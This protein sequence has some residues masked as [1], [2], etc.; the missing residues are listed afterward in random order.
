MEKPSGSTSRKDVNLR[1]F[2]ARIIH[3]WPFFGALCLLAV[4]PTVI[5]TLLTHPVYEA[6]A[7]LSIPSYAT[8]DTYS[9]NILLND[10]I[11]KAVG[12]KPG[13]ASDILTHIII[14]AD[15]KDKTTYRITVQAD[16]GAQ[17]ALEAN[18]WAEQ[19]IRWISQNLL[20]QD[21]P[22]ANKTRTDLKNADQKLLDFL[23]AQ[24][25][26]QYSLIDL[27]IYEG[28]YSP[29]DFS[30]YT[31]PLEPLDLSSDTHLELG[32]LLRDELNAANNYAD[33]VKSAQQRPT[34]VANQRPNHSQPRQAAGQARPT[35]GAS[36]GKKR[37]AGIG[38]EFA[39]RDLHSLCGRLVE[40]SARL[41]NPF[42][43][44]PYGRFPFP[45]SSSNRFTN[46]KKGNQSL[47]TS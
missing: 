8:N 3:R 29:G 24:N 19:G 36:S 34:A 20:G 25:L 28:L 43:G 21:R 23:E 6:T 47:L 22:W 1:G 16:S 39:N 15:N 10:N 17:A 4:V 41:G 32:N 30:S 37:G 31:P 33:A 2:L 5:L 42:L 13:M 26:T 40:K 35:A 9:A 14:N 46:E 11:I 45:G 27:R 18:T 44:P 7:V 12:S 38:S